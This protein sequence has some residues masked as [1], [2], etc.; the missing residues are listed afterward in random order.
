LQT[1]DELYKVASIGLGNVSG[2]ILVIV[3]H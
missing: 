3:S 2:Q 1:V